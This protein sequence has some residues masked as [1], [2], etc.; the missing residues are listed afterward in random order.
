MQN[1]QVFSLTQATGLLEVALGS[2]MVPRTVPAPPIGLYPL[3]E[4]LFGQL[5]HCCTLTEVVF[6]VVTERAV[7]RGFTLLLLSRAPLP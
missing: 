3:L 4:S 5:R 6:G 2:L 7:R 1:L